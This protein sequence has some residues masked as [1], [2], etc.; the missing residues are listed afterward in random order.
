MTIK[1]LVLAGVAGAAV[2]AAVPSSPHPVLAQNNTYVA[3]DQG[4]SGDD[5][6]SQEM[7]ATQ[8]RSVE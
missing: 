1:T 5:Q 7:K 4:Q 6:S 8:A 3:P 2:L